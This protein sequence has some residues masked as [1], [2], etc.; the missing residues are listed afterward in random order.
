MTASTA[1]SIVRRYPANLTP[2]IGTLLAWLETADVQAVRLPSNEEVLL[3]DG[4]VVPGIFF[5]TQS[6]INLARCG[7]RELATNLESLRALVVK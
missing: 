6:V 5:P 3:V 2:V 4:S 1:I 7:K